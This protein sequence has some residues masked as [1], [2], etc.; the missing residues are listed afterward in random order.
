MFQYTLLQHGASVFLFA[1]AVRDVGVVGTLGSIPQIP[2]GSPSPSA[3]YGQS[4]SD[5]SG[6]HKRCKVESIGLADGPDL[7]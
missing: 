5:L 1:E 6:K 2:R 3:N 4:D 7:S